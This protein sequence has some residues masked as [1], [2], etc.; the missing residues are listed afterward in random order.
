MLETTTRHAS[1][2]G[3]A[4]D[5]VSE[6]TLTFPMTDARGREWSAAEIKA[7]AEL[8]LADRFAR[9]ATVEQRWPARRQERRMKPSRRVAKEVPVFVVV[10]PNVLLLDVAGPMEVLRKANFEQQAVRFVATYVGPAPVVGSSIGLSVAGVAPLPE[11]LPDGA[12]VLISGSVSVPMAAT[13]AV[14]G[15]VAGS[16]R[17]SSRG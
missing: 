17:R 16:S 15:D 7:G 3:F 12:L 14:A 11:R 8:V 4:V 10:P 1:D 6:A 2:L 5:F 9:I 13:A